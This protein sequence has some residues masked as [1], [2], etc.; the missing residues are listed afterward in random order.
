M[1]ISKLKQNTWTDRIRPIFYM[2]CDFRKRS[3]FEYFQFFLDELNNVISFVRSLCLCLYMF[4]TVSKFSYWLRSRLF[5]SDHMIAH[6]PYKSQIELTEVLLRSHPSQKRSKPSY[7]LP[8]VGPATPRYFQ[9]KKFAIRGMIHCP[10]HEVFPTAECPSPAHPTAQ[11]RLPQ[12]FP[13]AP[14]LSN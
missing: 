6:H 2:K 9:A 7:A 4:W 10:L 5:S 11:P 1:Y 13:I 14:L 8:Q 3:K 12:F